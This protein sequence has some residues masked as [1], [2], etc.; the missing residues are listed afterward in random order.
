MDLPTDRK[1]KLWWGNVLHLS[2]GWGEDEARAMPIFVMGRFLFVWWV[3]HEIWADFENEEFMLYYN[4]AWKHLIKNIWKSYLFFSCFT[5]PPMLWVSFMKWRWQHLWLSKKK[6]S[7]IPHQLVGVPLGFNITLECFT[8][9]H[10]TSLN[11]WTRE[12]GNMI[13]DSRKYR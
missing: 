8:E 3:R 4:K 1:W 7:Q 9:A 13:H 6:F 2:W 11:Y 12:D 10:P 5:V